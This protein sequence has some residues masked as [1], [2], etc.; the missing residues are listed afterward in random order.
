MRSP[1]SLPA[2][3]LYQAE[4]LG[5]RPAVRWKKHGWWYGYSWE[6]LAERALAVAAALVSEGISPG[7]RVGLWSENRIEWILADLGI[8]TAGAVT[9]PAHAPLPARQVIQQMNHAEV[10][11]VFV[12]TP[13]M[14]QALADWAAQPPTKKLVCFAADSPHAQSWPSFLS[15]GWQKRQQ[16]FSELAQRLADLSRDT[17]ATIMYTSGTTGQ[18]KG[19]MLTHG[20]LL[21]NAW[22]MLESVQLGPQTV[23]LSWLPYSHIYGRLVDYY[24]SL[25]GG[26][27]LVLAES[28]DSIVEDLRQVQ[29]TSFAAVPRVYEKILDA[30][31][32]DNADH[33]RRRLRSIFGPR[34]ER[35]N[36][37]GAPL[38]PAIAQA[39]W[40]AGLPLLQ[41]YGLTETSPV[42]SFNRLEHNKL[43]TVGQAVPGVEIRIAEDGEV[44]V[45][46][47]N[48]TP[49]YWRHPEA[50]QQALVDG[51]FHTGDLGFLDDQGF[52][53]ITGRKKDLLV[54]S[55]GKKV[56]PTEL[57][58]LLIGSPHIEQ[59][60]VYGDGRSY[61]TA[62]IVPREQTL[63]Q[64]AEEHALTKLSR[65]S[66]V[67]HDAIRNFFRSELDRLLAEQPS[68]EQIRQFVLLP[69]PF[70]VE[71]EEVTV[72]LKV[73][74]Q[75]VLDKYRSRLEALY[76]SAGGSG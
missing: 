39:Y 6:E 33:Q 18:C 69:R 66:L 12:S 63:Q 7:A 61:L 2:L 11:L 58:N 42:V 10:Q 37:G 44:L 38:A 54:L 73:R 65:E 27:Q 53:T 14:A 67:E 21:S 16:Y 31:R 25:A 64:L 15:R 45:R 3:L 17:L 72:S 51:W 60:V 46:G 13:A 22:A 41:G 23:T 32:D 48:V 75:F 43:G 62:L 55:N 50:T 1:T 40:D 56:V 74:R 24:L 9:V 49:G 59:A 30:C 29:P 8:L 71:A 52:L 26:F 20:N 35:L 47:P 5:N 19:V 70:S 68:W 4:R 28:V 76:H 36:S 34:I 57:E